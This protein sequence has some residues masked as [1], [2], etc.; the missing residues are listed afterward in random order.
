M[1][2]LL[3]PIDPVC[4]PKRPA[5][6]LPFGNDFAMPLVL[7]IHSAVTDIP[8]SR[9]GRLDASGDV[10]GAAF[11]IVH[12]GLPFRSRAEERNSGAGFLPLP[13]QRTRHHGHSKK[14]AAQAARLDPA[15]R[16]GA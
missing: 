8:S 11:F 13:R 3:K 4:R 14:R 16:L 7:D 15:S 5:V 12:I 2:S 9:P 6:E 10:F 1:G